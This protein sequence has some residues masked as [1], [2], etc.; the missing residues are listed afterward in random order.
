[1]STTTVR[2]KASEIYKDWHV[3]DAA[4]RPLGRVASEAAKLLRGKHK[5]TFEPHLDDGDFVIIIN[6]AEVTLSGNKI[7]QVR[8]HRHTGYPGG[9]RTRTFTEQM[10]R[11][12]RK[13]LESAVW[14]MLPKGTLGEQMIRHLKVYPGPTHPHQSQIAGSDRAKAARESAAAEA[15][16]EPRKIRRLRPL[17]VPDG[18][19]VVEATPPVAKAAAP[20]RKR[21]ARAKAPAAP[22]KETVATPVAEAAPVEEPVA[23]APAAV[24]EA[25]KPRRT[26]AAKAAT[27]TEAATAE[28]PKRTRARKSATEATPA[29]AGEEKPKRTRKA[30]APKAEGRAPKRLPSRAVPAQRRPNPKVRNPDGRPAILLRHRPP[31]DIRRPRPALPRQ[32]RHRRQRQADGRRAPPRD[33]LASKPPSRSARSARNPTSAPRSSALAAASPAGP[34]PSAWASPAPSWLPTPK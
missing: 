6:A 18:S 34:A 13:V 2:I 23:A 14:G 25:P 22:A 27:T 21:P 15:L 31:Q 26:R 29:E 28:A 30:A 17:S 24:E 12:P 1:M 4:G 5:P 16:K 9:L 3:I 11:S 33:S 19:A 20:A 32:R 10:N 7:E 8:Y